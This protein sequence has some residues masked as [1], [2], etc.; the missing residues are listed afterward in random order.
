MQQSDEGLLN[1]LDEEPSEIKEGQSGGT[2]RGPP[3]KDDPA[4]QL[5]CLA[6][7]PLESDTHRNN[8]GLEAALDQI[9]AVLT[10]KK[11]SPLSSEA[12][13]ALPELASGAA[14]I[15]QLPPAPRS[16]SEA[17]G[18]ALIRE[19]ERKSRQTGS[20]FEPEVTIGGWKIVRDSQ[21]GSCRAL[22]MNET[23][24]DY[25]CQYMVKLIKVIE[26]VLAQSKK[27]DLTIAFWRDFLL[28]AIRLMLC[29]DK[30]TV[31]CGL[32][33]ASTLA[34][35]TPKRELPEP[36]L[37]GLVQAILLAFPHP[38]ILSARAMPM[39]TYT[40][41]V[42]PVV[43]GFFRG[44]GVPFYHLLEG[45]LAKGDVLADR[46]GEEN[47]LDFLRSL[48]PLMDHAEPFL[49]LHLDLLVP[50]LLDYTSLGDT[51]IMTKLSLL[52]NAIHKASTPFWV[53]WIAEIIV[54]L[55]WMYVE[56]PNI[57]PSIA[58]TV[59]A[60][61]KHFERTEGVEVADILGKLNEGPMGLANEY[62][63][64]VFECL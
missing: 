25:K 53:D 8:K 1:Q 9:Y 46:G 30:N 14:D 10:K 22:E 50:I 5:P 3:I 31:V 24:I 64:L 47:Y 7:S 19:K 21:S 4:E 35:L 33:F 18:R 15:L 59:V 58:T 41:L 57:R 52:T 12:I 56:R 45:I 32:H 55:F 13:L 38:T 20:T 11:P 54:K 48:D 27:G 39:K 44:N 60:L 16:L 42:Q 36:L 37:Q 63:S 34:Q 61:R 23:A 29:E 26:D 17:L 28:I 62:F 49:G 2:P 51:V 6:Q 40:S 43:M